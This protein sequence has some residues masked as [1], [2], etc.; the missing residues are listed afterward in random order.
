MCLPFIPL[1]PPLHPM[2][3]LCLV[4]TLRADLCLPSS[5]MASALS[6]VQFIQAGEKQ[7][8]TDKRYLRM[9]TSAGLLRLLAAR[10]PEKPKAMLLLSYEWGKTQKESILCPPHSR[11]LPLPTATAGGLTLSSGKDI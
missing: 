4:F 5:R 9:D 10:F 11:T 6:L 3:L 8:L 1:L 2:T 7:R